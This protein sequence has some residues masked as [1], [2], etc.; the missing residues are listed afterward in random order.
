MVI[1]TSV[2]D[3][4]ARQITMREVRRAFLA[5]PSLP[6]ELFQMELRVDDSSG[7]LAFTSDH[8][9]KLVGF[10][11]PRLLLALSEGQGLDAQVFEAA[12]A[13]ATS[14]EN[15]I[16]V[17]GNPTIPVGSFHTAATS[18]NWQT[19][20]IPCSLHPNIVSG[21]E[22]IPGGPSSVYRSRVLS[23]WPDESV[24]GLLKRSW[25]LEAFRKHESGELDDKAFN[26][27]PPNADDP[28]NAMSQ[29]RAAKMGYNP[30]LSVDV[31]RFGPDSS[32]LAVIYGAKVDRLHTWHGKSTT[33][34]A[35]IIIAH[36]E[37]LWTNRDVAPPRIVVDDGGVGGG[38]TDALRKAKWGV[39]AYNGSN[40]ATDPRK[41]L[42]RR[43]EAH[44][45]LRVLL[46]TNAIALPRDE[47]LLEE[48]LAVEYQT[49]PATGAIQMLSKETI[50]SSIGRSPDR[51][52]AIV[53]GLW[54]T[55]GRQTAWWGT[56]CT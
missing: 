13:C 37:R 42:N 43:A 5:T 49:V 50:R 53:Q 19:L 17:Y 38:V 11:H 39:V 25:L 23:E 48:A 1:A 35:D 12:N 46:E 40:R 34:T 54:A 31:A 30:L 26:Y 29:L 6:G 41:H 18:D 36:A 56:V 10:H 2:T 45:R 8:V 47:A 24:E 15:K 22:E 21:R 4:Q 16:V 14:E 55:S 28:D 44:W 20:T 51:L 3:R 32:V 7:I 9:E 33:D 52:D 27:R